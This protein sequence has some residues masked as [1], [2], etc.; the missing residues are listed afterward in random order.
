[1][2]TASF[3][4]LLALFLA[5]VRARGATDPGVEFTGIVVS[6]G[7]TRLAL[8][9]KSTALTQWVEQGGE[10][11]GVK[12]VNY[13]PKE[14]TIVVRKNGEE[15]RLPLV[16]TK[17]PITLASPPPAASPASTSTLSPA[18]AA[19]APAATIALP[20]APEGAPAASYTVKTGDTL[21]TIA[22]TTGV[23]M[24][25]LQAMN[26]TI[27]ANALKPGESIRTR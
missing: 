19:T 22:A 27:N 21:A 17:S 26:P 25:Q 13:E 2:R 18:P 14:D 7:V 16:S 23:T 6:D 10:F 15:I 9:E 5:G 12:V 11:K 4:V 8:T 24:E 20:P 3:V 1:M